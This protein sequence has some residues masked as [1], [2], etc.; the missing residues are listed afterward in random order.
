M[1]PGM[2]ILIA[3]SDD[4]VFCKSF[5]YHT[6][7]KKIRVENHHLYDLA[8]LTKITATLPL[9][10]KEVDQNNFELESPMSE[11]LPELKGSNKSDLSVKQ[12]LSHYAKLMPWIPFYEKTVDD[13]GQ[14]LRKFYRNRE[15]YRFDISVAEKLYL[16]S[17]FNKKIKEQIIESS[18][19]DSLQYRYSDL[20]YYLFKDYFERKYRK[21]LNYLVQQFLFKPLGLNRTFYNPLNSIPNDEIVPTELD[22]YFRQRELRGYVHDMGA[23]MQGGVGG[24]AGVFSN[25]E[26]VYKI[27]QIY[28][29]RGTLNGHKFFS[30]KTFETW[31]Q[32]FSIRYSMVW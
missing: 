31:L 22:D 24:H 17:N 1:T 16:K 3:K 30:S 4:I 13:N 6:Y 23:A 5:G 9:I 25:A 32:C 11:L 20:P 21:S 15:T 8:S 27:M 2:Q 10:I 26:E 18:L 7:D 14:P 12:V 28:L 29:H 19:L